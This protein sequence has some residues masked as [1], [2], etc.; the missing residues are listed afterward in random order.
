VPEGER[1]A[2]DVALHDRSHAHQ[3]PAYV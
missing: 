1:K 3:G 2:L